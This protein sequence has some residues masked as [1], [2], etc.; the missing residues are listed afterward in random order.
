MINNF[1]FGISILLVNK[2]TKLPLLVECSKP[3]E[4]PVAKNVDLDKEKEGS[5][6]SLILDPVARRR[7]GLTRK[8]HMTSLQPSEEIYSCKTMLQANLGN[9]DIDSTTVLGGGEINEKPRFF[10]KTQAQERCNNII[11]NYNPEENLSHLLHSIVGLDRYPNYLLRWTQN[12]GENIDALEHALQKQLDKVRQQ[13]NLLLRRKNEIARLC[14]D[15]DV[16]EENSAVSER[17]T[18]LFSSLQPPQTWDDVR[19]RIL[20]PKVSK[21]IFGSRMFCS[22]KSGGSKEKPITVHDVISGNINVHLDPFLVYELLDEEMLD[23]YSFPL[24]SAEV[25][26]LLCL[27]KL[28]IL[29]S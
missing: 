10:A 11:D 16:I 21:T 3:S 14:N 24:F 5:K 20:H 18:P 1:I 2:F 6:R 4:V 7:R 9:G 15:L 22:K 19:E 17:S 29:S 13:R 28:I 26:V 23:V 12:D 8:G 25:G 27:K